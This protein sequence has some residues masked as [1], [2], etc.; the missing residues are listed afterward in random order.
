M[1]VMWS[2]EIEKNLENSEWKAVENYDTYYKQRRGGLKKN[3]G[4]N[5][6]KKKMFSI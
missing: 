4:K 5:V 6:K 3:S 1:D 2:T